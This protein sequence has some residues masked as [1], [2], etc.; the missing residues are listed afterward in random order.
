LAFHDM[1]AGRPTAVPGAVAP[2][3]AR[4]SFWTSMGDLARLVMRSR[5]EGQK[6]R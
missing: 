4:F 5:A 1:M 3:S 6:S 2:A